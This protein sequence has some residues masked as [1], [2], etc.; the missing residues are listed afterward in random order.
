MGI[1]AENLLLNCCFDGNIRFPWQ[2]YF[3]EADGASGVIG[4][5]NE[6]L[7]VT[8]NSPGNTA[9]WS[10]TI[11]ARHQYLTL[12]EGHEY[13]NMEDIPVTTEPQTFTDTFT[14]YFDNLE[15]SDIQYT[16]EPTPIP[17]PKPD[18]RVNHVGYYPRRAKK[19][20]F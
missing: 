16:P 4:V 9:D 12:Q 19:Q 14:I 3:H 5:E 6:A 20:Q 17:L 7:Y 18:V 1:F 10:W 8:V 13:W 15:L 2:A 11:Q